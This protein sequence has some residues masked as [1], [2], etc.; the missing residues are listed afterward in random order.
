MTADPFAPEILRDYIEFTTRNGSFP[1]GEYVVRWYT[2]QALI[3]AAEESGEDL[4]VLTVE[5]VLAAT[6]RRTWR[7]KRTRP[8]VAR[9]LEQRRDG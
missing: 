8:S 5:D 1:F 7:E 4:F 6:P 9:L 3:E 2:V